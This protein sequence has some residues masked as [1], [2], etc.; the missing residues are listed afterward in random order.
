MKNRN[1]RIGGALLFLWLGAIALFAQT[2]ANEVKL[3]LREFD[4]TLTVGLWRIRLQG[5]VFTIEKNTAAAGDFSTMLTPISI[6]NDGTVTLSGGIAPSGDLNMGANRILF[7]DNQG[8]IGASSSTNRPANIW[9][10]T[11]IG[12]PKFTTTGVGTFAG[13]TVAANES[14]GLSGGGQ[15]NFADLAQDGMVRVTTNGTVVATVGGMSNLKT[16]TTFSP[17]S[18]SGSFAQLHVNPT[19]NGTSSGTAYGL[20]IASKTNTLTGGTIKLVS[21]GT[22]TTDGFTGYTP[23]VEVTNAGLLTVLNSQGLYMQPTAIIR[24]SASGIIEL[25]NENANAFTRLNFGGT[26]TGFSGISLSGAVG[27]H[28]QGFIFQRAD[29]TPQV[30]ANLGAATNG[31]VIYCSDCTFANPCAGSGTG[32]IAKRLN[33]AWRCD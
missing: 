15:I 22:T 4:Q 6:A 2:Q 16:G 18:G 23:L 27:G 30:F 31:S 26:T 10:G 25:Y 7:T 13:L 20:L 28:A 1:V 5:G 3:I 17:P 12:S 33:G 29:G 11:L 8:S 32:A 19:I 14:V 21:I 24:S 9:A